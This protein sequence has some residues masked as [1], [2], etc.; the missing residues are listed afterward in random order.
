MI[1]FYRHIRESMD[2]ADDVLRAA[3]RKDWQAVRAHCRL[4]MTS[5]EQ[6]MRE[7]PDEKEGAK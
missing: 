4:I 2:H 3:R 5:V 6:A 7:L 1:N